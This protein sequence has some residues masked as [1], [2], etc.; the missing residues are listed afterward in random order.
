MEYRFVDEDTVIATAPKWL[1]DRLAQP[2]TAS[3]PV[4]NAPPKA[5]TIPT[6]Q[7][8]RTLTSVAGTMRRKGVTQPAIE[9]A[10]LAD[11]MERCV[12]PLDASEVLA[13]AESVSRYEPASR[14]RRTE[15][16]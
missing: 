12:P 7:R 16:K 5:A 14:S 4:N 2:T 9:A 3:V 8:N 15:S 6:G 13:I 1:L 10:L 11:N